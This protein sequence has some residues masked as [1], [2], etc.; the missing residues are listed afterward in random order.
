MD[1]EWLFGRKGFHTRLLTNGELYNI[2]FSQE[3][4]LF[5]LFTICFIENVTRNV[6]IPVAIQGFILEK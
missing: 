6:L 3:D 5:N 4:S 2:I 1:P